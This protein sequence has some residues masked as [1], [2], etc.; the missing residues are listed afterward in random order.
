MAN[1]ISFKASEFTRER[2]VPITILIRDKRGQLRRETVAYAVG[3]NR[4]VA[5]ARAHEIISAVNARLN[6][7]LP[8]ILLVP[9][10]LLGAL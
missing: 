8:L 3:P 4:R 6:Q 10:M 1:S 7:V 5:A 9:S 2:R